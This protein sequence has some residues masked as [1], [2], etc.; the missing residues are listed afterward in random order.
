MSLPEL[1]VAMTL[2]GVLTT[3]IATV[4]IL[5]VRT[6]QD[7]QHRLEDSSQAE[8]GILSV[9]K[10]LRTA[11]LPEQSCVGCAG[12]AI[13]DAATAR[14]SFYANLGNTGQG[15]SLVTIS[16]VQDPN[17]P[18]TAILEE[19][20]QRP[21]PQAGGRYTFCN[22]TTSACAVQ[23]RTVARGLVWPAPASFAYYDF[24]GAPLTGTPLTADH[25]ARVSSIDV[26]V[27]VRG[28][29]DT[30]RT[31]AVQRV[32]LPNSDMPGSTS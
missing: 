21:I 17:R 7:L 8:G 9:S 19:R 13:V 29:A 24:A 16:V 6:S 31:T 25:L 18:G 26:S 27:A 3:M 30:P 28:A 5:G 1:L 15:P 12:T 14:L 32:R 20:T 22:P 23:T 10:V 11:A 4:A 2:L